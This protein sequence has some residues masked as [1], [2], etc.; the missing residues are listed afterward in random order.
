MSPVLFTT[1]LDELLASLKDSRFGCHIDGMYAGAIAC[2]DDVCLLAP[3]LECLR[4]MLTIVER[5]ANRFEIIFNAS[6]S[7]LL[8]FGANGMER[9]TLPTIRFMGQT[10]AS[11][12]STKHLGLEIGHNSVNTN[13]T[14]AVVDLYTRTNCIMAQFKHVPWRIRLRLFHTFCVHLYG[15]ECWD[16]RSSTAYEVAYRKCVRRIIGLPYR[17]HRALLPL[18]S[19]SQPLDLRLINRVCKFTYALGTS[20]NAL[21][22]ICARAARRGSG[23]I[24]SNNV[25]V[26]CARYNLP[27]NALFDSPRKFV[28]EPPGINER[29]TAQAIVDVLDVMGQDALL[30]NFNDDDLTDML[31]VLCEA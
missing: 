7:I 31:R 10:I 30:E 19:Q 24:L 12:P 22:R 16:L 15:C 28:P 29:A 5:F 25:S 26:I 1:Y 17:T 11:A 6:K 23:S 3:S 8:R 21:V 27:R 13:M 14:K 9:Q 2:A 18:V 4:K 20:S